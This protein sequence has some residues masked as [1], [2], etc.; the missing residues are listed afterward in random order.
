MQNR[1]ERMWKLCVLQWSVDTL[2][3]LFEFY[4]ACFFQPL[5]IEYVIKT[6]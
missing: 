4:C 3:L 2:S 6:A 5:K 1:R